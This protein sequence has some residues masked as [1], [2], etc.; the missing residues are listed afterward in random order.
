ME[1]KSF[2]KDSFMLTLDKTTAYYSVHLYRGTNILVNKFFDNGLA[3]TKFFEE[4]KKK[5]SEAKKGRHKRMAGL[6]RG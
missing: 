6:N 5:L 3:A 2:C 1:I 4:T